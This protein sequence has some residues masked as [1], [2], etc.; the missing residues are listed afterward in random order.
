[1]GDAQ[2]HVE[3]ALRL[4]P[5]LRIS[6]LKDRVSTMRPEVLAKFVDALRKAGL[7]E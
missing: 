1:L 3:R 4:D 7:P 5:D 6:R 2:K